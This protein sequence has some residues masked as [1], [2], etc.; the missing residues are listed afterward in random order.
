[1]QIFRL[2]ITDFRGIHHL[3]LAD[4][5]AQGIIM[6][7]GANESGK[8]SIL[9]ALE[10][11]FKYKSSSNA[12]PLVAA[13][14]YGRDVGPQ[15]T[16]HA[17]IGDCEFKVRKRWL[18]KK[19]CELQIVH[20]KAASYTGRAADEKLEA[21]YNQLDGDLR[22]ALF[23]QQGEL[24]VLNNL[25]EVEP[26]RDYLT[27]TELTGETTSSDAILQAAK[28]RYFHYFSTNHK[29]R[30]SE[31]TRYEAEVA[32]RTAQLTLL[33][34]QLEKLERSV[35]QMKEMEAS[36]SE[37]QVQLPALLE[38]QQVLHQQT[39]AMQETEHQYSLAQ[40]RQ[41]AL[42]QKIAALHKQEAALRQQEVAVQQRREQLQSLQAQQ[43]GLQQ[44]FQELQA[45][46][47]VANI[48]QQ[49]QALNAQLQELQQ[50]TAEFRAV[51][52]LLAQQTHLQQLQ[53]KHAQLEEL[54]TQIQ[55][56]EQI[57]TITAAQMKQV[58]QLHTELQ[59][60]EDRLAA[61]AYRVSL[62]ADSAAEVTIT[63]TGTTEKVAVGAEP[64]TRELQ[65]SACFTVGDVHLE[66]TPSATSMQQRQVT[67]ADAAAMAQECAVALAAL[68]SADLE[69][70]EEA[71]QRSVSAQA[72]LQQLQQQ[73]QDLAQ[74]ATQQE[75]T[76]AIAQVQQHVT[77]AAQQLDSAAVQRY[78]IMDE[79]TR[80]THGLQLQDQQHS[81]EQH[82]GALQQQ[83]N[84]AAIQEAR[85]NERAE[86]VTSQVQQLT[87]DID[88]ASATLENAQQEFEHDALQRAQDALAAGQPELEEYRQQLAAFDPELLRSELATAEQTLQQ[89]TALISRYEGQLE[90]LRT[91]TQQRAQVQRL[92]NSAEQNLDY[93]QQ[94]LEEA[95][96]ERAGT[97]LLYQKLQQKFDAM[98]QRYA[99]PLR[100]AMEE[101]A[102]AVYGEEVAF[103]ID[104]DLVLQ[105]RKTAAG[106]IP[107]SEL[108]GGAQEQLALIQRMSVARLVGADSAIFVD[109][110]LG[111]SDPERQQAM[112]PVFEQ[113]ATSSQ[114]FIMTC[115][116]QRFR[117][118][119]PAKRFDFEQPGALAPQ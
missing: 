53:Q 41:E 48:N 63:E 87:K 108:S 58:R 117:D 55:E 3:E 30:K 104:G 99:Q 106:T 70:A 59:R 110:P 114:V 89:T 1:M 5:P 38:R 44:E 100:L 54:H 35:V 112:L 62:H 56:V 71:F 90:Q 49:E 75:L 102:S 29:P 15:V 34:E 76:D 94:V 36:L 11:L 27:T 47:D 46:T 85:L 92:V 111:A 86:Q 31:V 95:E 97:Q 50:A 10:F 67:P 83:R 64:I 79:D 2:S 33:Q 80:K 96:L 14:P 7:A 9:R 24:K 107:I 21:I 26:L 68:S 103:D 6:V 13:Q 45:S 118:L 91:Q 28:Q 25:E 17:R 93:A 115:D 20:P 22:Q 98:T 40:Q 77:E 19:A 57:P 88:Q 60:I 69:Q 51:Q 109:D 65:E 18:R 23:V 113:A 61:Q 37:L 39:K 101:L 66:F 105:T 119:H 43:Q 82:I 74:G 84:H 116:P 8:S 81:V 32:E 4:L 52:N 12:G 73:R 78:T 42:Q 16:L 72:Q